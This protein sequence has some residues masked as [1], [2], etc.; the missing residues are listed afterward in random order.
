MWGEGEAALVQS[1]RVWRWGDG[2]LR[3]VVGWGRGVPGS[4]Q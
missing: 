4:V 1:E 3:A 2:T